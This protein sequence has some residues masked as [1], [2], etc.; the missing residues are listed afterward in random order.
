MT[1]RTVLLT[2]ATGI[3][4]SWVLGEA[5]ARGYRPIVLMRDPDR[6]RAHER[7]D[8]VLRHVNR[9]ADRSR[10][11]VVQGDTRRPHLGLADDL[12]RQLRRSVDMLIHC[13]A[14]TSFRP[15]QDDEVWATNVGGVVNLLEFLR[16]T[17]IPYYHVS[18]AYVSGSRNV[19]V[20]ESELDNSYGFN[21]T[22]ERSKYKAEKLVRQA[23]DEGRLR[24]AVFR[25]SIIVGSTQ[26]GRILQFMNFYNILRI[27]DLM[28]SRRP[29]GAATV[30]MMASE[31]GTKNLIPVDWTAQA[32]W[33]I[34]E[35]EGCSGLA[36][37]LTNPNPI[38][39][40][41]MRAW[42]N[43][44][45]RRNRLRI[46]LT[47][48]LDGDVSSLESLLEARLSNYRPY[49]VGEPQFDRANTDRALDGVLPFPRIDTAYFDMLVAFARAERWR[50]QFDRRPSPGHIP[51][52]CEFRPVAATAGALAYDANSPT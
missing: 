17:D 33:H 2:G 52:E 1:N 26:D 38:A 3:M 21:N 30:R 25:P 47:S 36:Y 29:N 37:H 43:N 20:F 32:V 5:L 42:A 45:L 28:A 10:V 13:A 31:Q 6:I 35:R 50:S 4:G 40:A 14:C 7:L 44:I 12:V 9:L 22:Y 51:D 11:H 46:R 15:D 16:D 19:R 8:T 18:T 39:H 34:I 49:L 23:F 24:G 27:V 41:E 48:E